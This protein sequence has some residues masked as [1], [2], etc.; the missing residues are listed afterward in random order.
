M[1]DDSLQLV[2]LHLHSCMLYLPVC[3][4][5]LHVIPP[6]VLFH[7]LYKLL[8]SAAFDD[9]KPDV[10]ICHFLWLLV[11]KEVSQTDLLL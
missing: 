11:A 5:F 3:F 7:Q 1:E 2:L 4:T 8:A 9:A 10:D 6:R